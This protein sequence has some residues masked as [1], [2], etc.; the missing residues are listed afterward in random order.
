MDVGLEVWKTQVMLLVRRTRRQRS[1]R[2]HDVLLER[3][4]EA[5]EQVEDIVVYFDGKDDS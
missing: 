5:V 1:Q 2:C 4:Q 3:S